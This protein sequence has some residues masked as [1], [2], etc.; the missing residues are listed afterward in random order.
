MLNL[1][2]DVLAELNKLNQKF[3]YDLV[4]ISTIGSTLDSSI[5][6]LKRHF[7]C[8]HRL[9]FGQLTKN[10]GSFLSQA[11]VDSVL[12]WRKIND[13]ESTYH[14]MHHGQIFDEEDTLD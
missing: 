7:L 13:V 3:Q 12:R 10:L 2:V 9:K 11:C 6:I 4:D 5:S 8:G 1:V 14:P